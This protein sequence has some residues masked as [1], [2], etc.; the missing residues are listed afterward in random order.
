KIQTMQYKAEF[1]RSSGG[2]LSVVTKT[3]TN[4]LKGSAYEFYRNKAL[5]SRSEHDRQAGNPKPDFTR[6][7]YGASLGGPLVKDRAHSFA[8]YEKLKDETTQTVFTGGVYPQYDGIVVPTPLQD[9][10]VTAKASLEPAAAQ[11]LQVRY[12]YQKNS[13]AYNGS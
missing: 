1:G 6:N 4:D 3:G 7:Q 9:E 10:L 2:V 5:T 8:T 11:L 13:N 12:G